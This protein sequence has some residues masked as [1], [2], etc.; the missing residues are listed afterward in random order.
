MTTLNT[1]RRP[2]TKPQST[3]SAILKFVGGLVGELVKNC[4]A[5]WLL[6]SGL[7]KFDISAPF[8]GCLLLVGAVSTV[9][10]SATLLGAKR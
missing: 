9:M 1:P 7:D 3:D 2:A 5:A 4:V 6:M 8:V 10:N